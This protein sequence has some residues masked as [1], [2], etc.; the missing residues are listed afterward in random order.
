MPGN[1]PLRPG[2]QPP[3]A[4]PKAGGKGGNNRSNR[5]PNGGNNRP[6]RNRGRGGNPA[7]STTTTAGFDYTGVANDP[8]AWLQGELQKIG[9]DPFGGGDFNAFLNS[10][11]VD[12]FTE[13]WATYQTANTGQNVTVGDYIGSLGWGANPYQS[14]QAPDMGRFMDYLNQHI[15]RYSPRARG[16]YDPGKDRG[17]TRWSV[18]V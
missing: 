10:T 13:G 2:E 17:G 16:V 3:L 7:T 12:P 6:N 5:N 15:A 8:G 11:V 18:Y 4:G 9:Y 1:R 14:G